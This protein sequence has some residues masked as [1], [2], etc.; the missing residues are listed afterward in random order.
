[1]PRRD[2]FWTLYLCNSQ[3][4]QGSVDRLMEW[5][6]SPDDK[7]YLDRES[8]VLC[9]LALGWYLTSSNR[10]QRDLAT[11]GLVRLFSGHLA[12]MVEVMQA[13]QD[14]DDPYVSERLYCAAYGCALRSRESQSLGMLAMY[15][16][17]IIFK[18]QRPP[19]NILL[20]DYARGIIEYAI[21][22]KIAL[23]I[24]MRRVRP[25]YKSAW[26]D[27]IPTMGALRE[28]YG[29]KAGAAGTDWK[30]WSAIYGSVLGGGDF[31]RYVIGTNSGY[32]QWS[33]R[34]ISEPK[35]EP[36][37]RRDEASFDLRVA[38]RWIF[39]RVVELGW[40]P[41]LFAE[42]D[43]RVNS[44][45]YDRRP[46]KAERIGKKYQWI[47]FYEFLARISDNFQYIG[48]R[49]NAKD[50]IFTGPWQVGY[51][52]NID[53]SCL[54]TN[55]PGNSKSAA[56]WSP[57]KYSPS[58]DV[59]E[60][61]WLKMT[62]DLP[63]P[64]SLLKVQRPSDGSEW[65][66]LETHRSFEDPLPLGEERFDQPFKRLW[67]MVKSYLVHKADVSKL[68]GTLEGK[69]F[70][71]RWMPESTE[72]YKILHGEYFWSPAYAANDTPHRGHDAWTRGEGGRRQ[73]PTRVCVTAL[74]FLKE[75]VYDCSVEE[76]IY[77][78]FPSKTLAKGMSV[79]WSGRDG[80]FC[81]L[82]G[83]DIAFD[84]AANEAGPHALL[85]RQ[86]EF[87]KFLSKNNLSL[88]WTILGAK[89]GMNSGTSHAEWNGEMRINGLY[90]FVDG[91][92]LG[93]FRTEIINKDNYS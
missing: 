37:A 82:S 61:D 12:S 93:M 41:S 42:F 88:L 29:Y 18:D 45:S 26:T 52:R 80:V 89:E 13:F 47:A 62:G 92:A 7:S 57:I 67:Y 39:N 66:V 19:V 90:Q 75:R 43:R 56:W 53:P 5:A 34:K 49:W 63:E 44:W 55:D 78:L 85:V 76:S 36:R 77:L 2:A 8:R 24:N 86:D 64:M 60:A 25:V 46:D 84:P 51:V 14:V 83:K 10:R 16:Y 35:I 4:K 11:K 30:D 32:F 28:Q 20:R 65:L 70:W 87:D 59:L 38:Q 6:A 50:T 71:G 31:E 81:D 72:E 69:S 91:T 17:S 40:T 33:S 58:T 27:D 3:G 54:L 48:D 74:G 9:G 23:S 79:E 68:I 22:R 15:V 1:M 21:H 73:L